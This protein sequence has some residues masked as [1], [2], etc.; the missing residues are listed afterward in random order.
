[1]LDVSDAHGAGAEEDDDEDGDGDE[2]DG[3]GG[4]YADPS[5]PRSASE[6]AA[7]NASIAAQLEE[8]SKKYH[9]MS[10]EQ[11]FRE[12]AFRQAAAVVRSLPV[13]LTNASQLTGVK[14][15]GASILE[16]VRS[17]LATG[18][19]ARLEALKADPK[20]QVLQ[21][22]QT[23]HGIGPAN[24]EKLYAAGVRS[25]EDLKK[26]TIPLTVQQALSLRYHS[27]LTQPIPR[28]EV[29]LFEAR[30]RRV[31]AAI[32]PRL[33]MEIC[34]SYRRGK[35]TCGDIDVL[36]SHPDPHYRYSDEHSRRD[37][38]AAATS[39]ALQR[40]RSST[41]VHSGKSSLQYLLE[42]LLRRLHGEGLLTDDLVLPSSGKSR[43]KTHTVTGLPDPNNT[44]GEESETYSGIGLLPREASSRGLGGVH[45]RLDIKVYPSGVYPFAVLYFTGCKDFN[46]L[47]RLYA[48]RHHRLSLSDR[49]LTPYSDASGA[50]VQSGALKGHRVKV[51]T[52]RPIPC[53]S[54]E[55]IFRAVGLDYIPPNQRDIIPQIFLGGR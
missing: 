15:I 14:G 32:D 39:S 53:A 10:R 2:G 30:I 37:A 1:M 16:E 24:A 23:V 13:A 55:E 48:N 43:S 8:V 47:M 45:R 35:P 44:P 54:E 49:A 22:L 41:S 40:S 5:K 3:E 11:F 29:A 33:R 12:S 9:S 52:G 31:L 36:I 25:I 28:A 46:R 4:A 34:G 7:W 27:E 19:S 17:I 38:S 6:I 20:L 50:R 26:G 18:H 42:E 51:A 21:L